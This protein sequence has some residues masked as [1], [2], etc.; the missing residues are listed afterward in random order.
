MILRGKKIS[1]P[2]ALRIGLVH[3]VCPL[4]ELKDRALTLAQELAAQPATAVRGVMNVIV[5]SEDRDLDALLQ[6]ERGAVMDTFGTADQQE[7]MLAFLEKRKPVF[8]Q[9]SG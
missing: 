2:E 8:N 3:E 7:G 4:E 6:A 9:T 1:G 5:G